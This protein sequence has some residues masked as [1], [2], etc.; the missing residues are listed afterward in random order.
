MERNLDAIWIGEKRLRVN[1]PRFE[2]GQIGDNG[3]RN[4]GQGARAGAGKRINIKPGLREKV[5]YARV[6][7]HGTGAKHIVPPRA[8]QRNPINLMLQRENIVKPFSY[9]L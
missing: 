7:S 9:K 3:R 4:Q 1:I 5:T 2:R 8:I 6:L